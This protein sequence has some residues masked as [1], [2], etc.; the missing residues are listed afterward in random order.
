MSQ[1]YARM[2]SESAKVMHH[3]KFFENGPPDGI[4]KTIELP[5]LHSFT[6]VV[7]IEKVDDNEQSA[8]MNIQERKTQIWLQIQ[9]GQAFLQ[10]LWDGQLMQVQ[11]AKRSNVDDSCP[12]LDYA[13][14]D[15]VVKW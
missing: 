1:A 8:A 13:V 2:A 15:K 4:W 12:Y 3:A 7:K 14:F 6:D 11:R 10:R 5:T 9:Q